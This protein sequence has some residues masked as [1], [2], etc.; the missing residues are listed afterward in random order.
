LAND[1]YK[2]DPSTPGPRT[3]EAAMAGSAQIYFVESLEVEEYYADGKEI[4]LVDDVKDLKQI[5]VNYLD[6]PQDILAIGKAAQARTLQQH[7]YKH[8]VSHILEKI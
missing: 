7:T 3:F 2:L 1:R 6:A 4:L 5:L 8:R